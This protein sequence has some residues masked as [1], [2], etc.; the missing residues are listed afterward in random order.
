MGNETASTFAQANG[1]RNGEWGTGNVRR[2][3][4]QAGSLR[5]KKKQNEIWFS[6]SRVLQEKSFGSVLVLFLE[7]KPPAVC[8]CWLMM[9]TD[10]YLLYLPS[11]KQ[12]SE[13]LCEIHT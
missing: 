7:P 4:Q 3:S 11:T 6:G 2:L 1:T 10:V 9:S 5:N 13:E 8:V 12:R